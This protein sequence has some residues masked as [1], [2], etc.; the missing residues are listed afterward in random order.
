[1]Q[2]IKRGDYVSHRKLQVVAKVIRINGNI[3]EV[4]LHRSLPHQFWESK[5]VEFFR[6][7]FKLSKPK[8]PK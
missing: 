3:Y 6:K 8:Y 2:S 5:E 1:M 4:L 7:A